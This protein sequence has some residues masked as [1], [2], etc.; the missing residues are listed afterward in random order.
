MYIDIP[1]TELKQYTVESKTLIRMV[2]SKFNRHIICNKIINLEYC[3]NM[4]DSKVTQI[5]LAFK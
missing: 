5:S 4:D 1:V 2:H 3:N